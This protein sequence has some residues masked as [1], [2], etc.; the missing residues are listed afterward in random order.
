V[1]R[2]VVLCLEDDAARSLIEDMRMHPDYPLL[3]P[4]QET[5]VPA[6]VVASWPARDVHPTLDEIALDWAA[7]C[8]SRTSVH[9]QDPSGLIPPIIRDAFD[10]FYWMA[11]ARAV[12][13]AFTEARSDT[14]GRG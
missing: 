13:H 12:L 11:I 4:V 2:Y 5:S 6:R 9:R 1:K 14:V 7:V 10:R 8:A 3:T